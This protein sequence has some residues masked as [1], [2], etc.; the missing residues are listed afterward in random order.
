MQNITPFLWFDGRVEEATNLYTSLFPNSKV[1]FINKG[2]DGKVMWA[3]VSL[4]GSEYMLFNGGPSEYK[5]NESI[6][7]FVKCKDQEEVDK[8][9]NTL[10]SDGG[11]ESQC[12]W[13][14]DK[15]GVSWQIVPNALSECLSNPDPV[16]AGKAMQ[17]MLKMKKLI[18]KDLYASIV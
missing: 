9:W 12:G 6:S 13:L 11:E 10:T 4:N 5:F 7:F 18:V 17:A 3:N 16:K 2:P 15:F 8:Y 1:I 14:K